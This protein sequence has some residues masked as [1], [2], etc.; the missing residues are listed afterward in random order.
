MGAMN[1]EF[2]IMIRQNLLNP[3]DFSVILG[4]QF[5]NSNRV[6]RLRRYNGKSHWHSNRI[7]G[8]VFYD[9]H[10]HEATERYQEIGAKED[11][12]AIVSNEFSVLEEAIGCLFEDC[13]FVM[14]DDA[15]NRLFKDY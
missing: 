6:F 5:P 7:E 11:G 4:Y 10:I 2:V 14:P 3:M 8:D 12:Y 15:Q 9:Y 13:G 1:S